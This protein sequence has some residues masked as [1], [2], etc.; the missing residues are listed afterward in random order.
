MAIIQVLGKL[1]QEDDSRDMNINKIKI[2]HY[3]LGIQILVWANDLQDIERLGIFLSL[4]KI[5]SSLSLCNLIPRTVS[6][7][8]STSDESNDCICTSD[9]KN[10]VDK[11]HAYLFNRTNMYN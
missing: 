3:S 10:G 8:L 9:V 5:E 2:N 1:R 4:L 6:C 7:P 11:I